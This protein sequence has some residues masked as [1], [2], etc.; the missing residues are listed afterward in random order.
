MSWWKGIFRKRST[1]FDGKRLAELE[2]RL[3]YRF[4]DI[5]LVEKALRH[6]SSLQRDNLDASDSNELMEFLGDAVIGLITAEHLYLEFPDV[7]EGKLTQIKSVVVSGRVLGDKAAGIG[8]GDFLL[9]GTG[10]SRNG[11]R[12]RP[13]IL[14]DAFEAMVGAIYLDGGLKAAEDFVHKILLSDIDDIL[15]ATESKNF[16]SI[17][18][19][20]AQANSEGQPYYKVISED[21]PD[22]HKTFTIE[23]SIKGETLGKGVGRSKKRAEQRAASAALEKLNVPV[24]DI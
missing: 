23:V 4:Q 12:D 14:E 3:G 2:N 15:D 22:H 24:E 20:H 17:L 9:M 16:K 13:S 10:E 1:Q 21:G 18:L 6:R 7:D 19:E 5:S 11:G 8:L